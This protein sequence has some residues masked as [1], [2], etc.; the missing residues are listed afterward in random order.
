MPIQS[1]ALGSVTI[2]PPSWRDSTVRS[3]QAAENLVRKTHPERWG[4]RRPTRPMSCNVVTFSQAHGDTVDKASNNEKSDTEN[5]VWNNGTRPQTTGRMYRHTRFEAPFPPPSL[6]EQCAEVSVGLAFEYMRGVR[7]V[8]AQLRRQVSKVSKEATKLERERGHLEKV[9]QSLK[10]DIQVNKWSVEGRTR[11]PASTELERDGAD[12][13]LECEK[14]ELTELKRELESTLRNTLAQL[15]ILGQSSRQLL[16]CASERYR[17]LE[18]LPH[19]GS[20]SRGASPSQALVKPDPA[21]PFT[22]NCMQ[23]LKASLLA[24]QQSQKLREDIKQ[25]ITTTIAR[26][27]AAHRTVNDCLVKKIAETITLKQNLLVMSAAT[28]QAIFRQQRKLNCISHSHNAALGPKN[29]GDLLS[30]EKL[31]RPLVQIYHRHPGTQLLE[32]SHLLQGSAVLRRCLQSSENELAKL[33][34][35]CQQLTENLNAKRAAAQ[36]DSAV[37]RMRRQLVDQ[38]AVP[39]ILQQG[40]Y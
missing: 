19:S 4:S 29:S 18:L 32:A 38:R 25:R 7:E 8:E 15:Q 10:H 11:R 14:M 35:S 5:P 30:R 22:P 13:L 28:R 36:V 1:I 37:V 12:H 27:R 21:G 39:K 34:G 17:V 40:L 23:V 16:E 24:V 31:N 20:L 6:Q 26:Q 33:Q 3:I 2:G 9:L